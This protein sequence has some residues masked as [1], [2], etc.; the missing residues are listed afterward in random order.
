MRSLFVRLFVWSWL[1]MGLVAVGLVISSPWFTRSRRGVEDWERRAASMLERVATH[2]AEDVESRGAEAVT[3]PHE[4][5]AP[6]AGPPRAAPPPPPDPAHGAAGAPEPGPGAPDGPPP[7]ERR[8]RRPRFFDVW[9]IGEGGLV[10]KGPPAS[11]AA[12][13]VANR[14]LATDEPIRGR[15][16]AA[17]L[18]ARPATL[19]GGA[20]RVAV[21]V[22]SRTPPH[23]TDL[24]DPDALL[25]MAAGL[26][27]LTAGLSFWMSRSLTR[28]VGALREAVR[29]LRRG[30]L[31][32]RVAPRLAARRDE[33]GEL[34]REFNA[35]AERVE[36]L[37]ANQRRLT[38]DVSH[39]LRSPLARLHVA[40][41][42]ARTRPAGGEPGAASAAL[43]RIAR[44]AER[45]D[46][47]LEQLLVLSRLDAGDAPAGRERVDLAEVLASAVEDARFEASS[48][49][50]TI[51][52]DLTPGCA[53][54]ASPPLLASALDNVLRNAVRYSP[55]GGT[56]DVSLARVEAA[57]G[58]TA[59]AR[60]RVRDRGPGVPEQDLPR[61][62]EPFYRVDPARD[63]ASGGAGLGLAIAARAAAAHGGTIAA[64]HADGGGL[65]IELR[66]PLA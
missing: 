12:L 15:E 9:L 19:P 55:E 27:V 59:M 42:L 48:R 32:A 8:R 17:H 47:M 49:A 11:S 43:D 54:D 40:L 33:T 63:R 44:E 29:E 36:A 41:E 58:Q 45:L 52:A 24:L 51:A 26:L 56:V 57:P 34:A 22:G 50:I 5:L 28:P 66:L 38:R 7:G 4:D 25:P 62:F 18:S 39:E 35:M 60:I 2:V 53:A 6:P 65:E 21:V 31:A 10:V 46:G 16:G 1:M 3:F 23:T 30:N 64:R 20:G 37:I 14:A 13:D 61:I